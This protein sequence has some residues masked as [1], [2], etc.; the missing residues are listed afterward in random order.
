MERR[1]A[2]SPSPTASE[3][4]DVFDHREEAGETLAEQG[5]VVDHEDPDHCVTPAPSG[6][7]AR[8]VVPPPAGLSTTSEPPIS[9]ARSRMLDS[10]TPPSRTAAAPAP[11]VAYFNDHPVLDCLDAHRH[12]LSPAMV[13][14]IGHALAD[15]A[16]RRYLDR[17]GQA[18]AHLGTHLHAGAVGDL[19]TP[20]ELAQCLGKAQLVE[21]RRTQAL[22]DPAYVEHRRL[23]TV[24]EPHQG[25]VDG[26]ARLMRPEPAA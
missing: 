19:E 20:T 10:P 13:D 18:R 16:V 23:D 6:S 9:S 12:P 5:V 21:G 26:R 7:S 25:L 14:G 11:I 22:N 8:I 3:Y 17:G 4:L 15:N 24:A 1:T 2:V